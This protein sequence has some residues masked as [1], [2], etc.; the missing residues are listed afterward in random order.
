MNNNN[1]NM[2]IYMYNILKNQLTWLIILKIE[3][4]I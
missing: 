4:K 1:N 3:D 2:Q